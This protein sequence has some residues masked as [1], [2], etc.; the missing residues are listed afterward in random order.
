MSKPRILIAGYEIGGQMQLLAEAF[1]RKGYEAQSVAF[2]QNYQKF[3]NDKVLAKKGITGELLRIPFFLS[4]LFKYD[5]FYFF[6]GI[7][8]V[9]IWRFHRLDLPILKLFGKRIIVHFRGTD[10][11]NIQYYEN[12]A[13]P[14]LGTKIN[15]SIP[16]S[17]PDQLASIKKWEK[18]ADHI[19]VSTPD[20]FWVSPRAILSPQ[21]IEYNE[22]AKRRKETPNSNDILKIVHAPTRR[23]AK[24][25]EFIIHAIEQL[26]S[27]GLP[28]ELILLEKLPHSEIPNILAQCDIGIDQLLHGW[29]GKVS[30]ELMALGNP[31]ICYIKE[32]YKQYAPKLPIITA[33]PHT[34]KSVLR[35]LINDETLRKKKGESGIEYAYQHHDVDLEVIKLINLLQIN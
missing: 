32:D 30:V 7:S 20:L 6:W 8:L 26:I 13:A 25:T 21:I 23:Q 18:Y 3:N 14:Y 27:E 12:L 1:R 11:V 16:L 33:T 15:T 17:R 31:V 24:G 19:L 2:N 28:V 29:Y 22:W 10:V 34:L 9:S 35:Q 4:A 5:I